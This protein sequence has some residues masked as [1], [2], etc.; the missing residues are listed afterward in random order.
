[1][2][3]LD[4]FLRK[5]FKIKKNSYRYE[6]QV[7]KYVCIYCSSMVAQNLAF[8]IEA[9]AIPTCKA[10]R[11]RQYFWVV[12]TLADSSMFTS[13]HFNCFNIMMGKLIT[14]KN[15][16]K[17][18]MHGQTYQNSQEF[19]HVLFMGVIKLLG[20]CRLH[21]ISLYEVIYEWPK[22][23]L[24]LAIHNQISPLK[25][26][27]IWSLWLQLSI[28]YP[29]RLWIVKRTFHY[30][31]TTLNGGSMWENRKCY[32]KIYML[33]TTIAFLRLLWIFTE[34]VYILKIFC[35]KIDFINTVI[36]T[37]IEKMRPHRC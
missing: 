21:L 32:A 33:K 37:E 7:F 27:L 16:Q 31:K 28:Q 8:G 12:L 15:V 4:T 17:F 20:G 10:P 14:K 19:G 18:G 22:W 35:N 26:N 6:I 2:I 36:F 1:M 11:F 13:P 23:I 9:R 24:K 3:G 34:L 29:R 25:K 30:A 5:L